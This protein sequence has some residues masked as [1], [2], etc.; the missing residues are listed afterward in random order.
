MLLTQLEY[1]LALAREQ[2][3]GRAA[4]SVYVTPSTL[5]ESVRKL[6]T[7]LGTPLVRRGRSVQGLTPEG[8]IVQRWA[9]RIVADHQALTDE[10]A[11]ARQ[12]LAARARL[13]AIP[14]GVAAIAG[15][16]NALGEQHPLVTAS[17]TSGL[18]SEQIVSGI[19]SY[20][21]DAGVIHPSAA[22]GPDLHVSSLSP[23]RSVVVSRADVLPPELS[24]VTGEQLVELPLCLL[25]PRMR[26]RQLLDLRLR[27][28]GLEAHPR[29][30]ADSVEMLLSLVARGSWVAVIPESSLRAGPITGLRVLP[31]VVPEVLSP[32]ALVRM[33]DQPTSPLA[34]AIDAAAAGFTRP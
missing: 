14:S 21:L 1:F 4:S 3:F 32:L 18:T 31:L 11:A 7:E 12:W 30:E 23:V 16:L 5:S 34:H 24:E 15:I 2:H 26:A 8:E 6:E 33:A 22:D 13:G 28:H 25:E 19:R 27:E 10:I 20:E 17:V 29:V 9:R